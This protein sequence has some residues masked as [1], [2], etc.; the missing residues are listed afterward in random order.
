M[1][2]RSRQLAASTDQAAAVAELQASSQGLKAHL[3]SVHEKATKAPEATPPP[4]APSFEDD[5]RE[6]EEIDQTNYYDKISA[7]DAPLVVIDFYTQWCVHDVLC[8]TRLR[9][10]C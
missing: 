5:P 6:I 1:Q 2:Q 3:D 9:P 4:A 10:A 8:A 7:A